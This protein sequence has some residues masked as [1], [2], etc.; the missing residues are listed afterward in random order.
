MS[1]PVYV[2]L[3]HRP[4]AEGWLEAAR[5]DDERLRN[6]LHAISVVGIV[7]P[8]ALLVL[9][10]GLLRASSRAM[11]LEQ[12][13]RLLEESSTWGVDVF[14]GGDVLLTDSPAGVPA[15]TLGFVIFSIESHCPCAQSYMG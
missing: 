12:A 14:F 11:L 6:A 3:L 8:E 4:E 7:D 2:G 5:L 1:R 13:D 10:A 15:Q 9:P